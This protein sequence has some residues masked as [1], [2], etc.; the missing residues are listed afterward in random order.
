LTLVLRRRATWILKRI[1]ESQ[2]ESDAEIQE[3]FPGLA[4]PAGT[5]C[6]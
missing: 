2:G 1:P 3:D 4:G 5:K 6:R